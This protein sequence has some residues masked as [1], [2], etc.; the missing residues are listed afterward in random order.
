MFAEEDKY[1]VIQG[2][3]EHQNSSNPVDKQ[4]VTGE[5]PDEGPAPFHG[6]C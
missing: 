2:N 4:V 3:R 6:E 5:K 1:Q